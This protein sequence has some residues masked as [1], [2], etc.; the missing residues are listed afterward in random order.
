[1]MIAHGVVFAALAGLALADGDMALA[2]RTVLTGALIVAAIWLARAGVQRGLL[3][4]ALVVMAA[5]IIHVLWA[6]SG[7]LMAQNI[8]NLLLAILSFVVAYDL[9]MWL[10]DRNADKAE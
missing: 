2:G 10:F 6:M 3:A 5:C 4:V 8:I 7:G 9:F 1:M